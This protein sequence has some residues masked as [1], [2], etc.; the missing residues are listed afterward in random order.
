MRYRSLGQTGLQVS[1]IGLGCASFWGKASFDEATA[2][3]L[4]HAAIDHGVTFFDTGAA[5]S[6]GNAEPR[7]GRALSGHNKKQDLVIATKAGSRINDHGK[8]IEDFSPAGVRKTVE[9]SLARLGIEAISLLQLHGPEVSHLTDELVRTLEDLKSEGKVRC[10]GI[11]S[12]DDP[13]VR[14][15]MNMPQF[16]AVM[17]NY[18]VLSPDREELIGELAA[19]NLGIFAAMALGGGHYR[20]DRYAIRGVQD[21]WYLARAWKNH[22][23]ALRVGKRFSFMN[24][25]TQ[26]SGSQL[27]LAWA[28]RRP[29]IS[30]A[31]I[32]TTRLAH[33]MENIQAS[34]LQL[35]E[36]QLGKLTAARNDVRL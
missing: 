31:V 5:Y 26:L 8:R 25:D 22:R 33:L 12:F 6:G 30:C 28:L 36:S 9:Q 19:R 35:S 15:A 27:A 1:E 18:S 21:I 7:L 29:E 32:G 2:V 4:V 13:V 17:I 3:R 16:G 10:L 24:E 23:D 34:G 11:N 20:N 14:R